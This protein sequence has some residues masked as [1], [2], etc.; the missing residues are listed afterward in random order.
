LTIHHSQLTIH[1]FD[2]A[3]LPLLIMKKFYL[4]FASFLLA[5]SLQ[6]QTPFEGIITYKL[7]GITDHGDEAE[8]K[9]YFGK[10]VLRLKFRDK[11]FFDKEELVVKIDSGKT[12]TLN[13]KAK[14]YFGRPLFR[15]KPAVVKAD[16]KTIAG[17]KTQAGESMAFSISS[18]LG[19]R[20]RANQVVAYTAPDL[21]FP[22]PDSLRI[23]PEFLVI[24]DNHIALRLE[25]RFAREFDI[26]DTRSESFTMEAVEVIPMTVPT[27]D[28][29]IPPAGYTEDR[30][31]MADDYPADSV[32]VMV[33]T[34]VTTEAMEEPPPPPP[35]PAAPIAPKKKKNGQT[36]PARKPD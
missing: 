8:L 15:A 5:A 3:F 36:S 6:A 14:T 17:Y 31:F 1:H 24:H 35:P 33:D 20:F 26:T 10:N 12:Y 30:R 28:F 13:T 19:E 7:K 29:M 27:A 11:E 18:V 4:L 2:F 34:V 32:A 21:Y 25:A 22:V 9:V 23:N 16:E